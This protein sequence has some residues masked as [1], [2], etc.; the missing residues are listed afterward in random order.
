MKTYSF[1][2]SRS[3][4]AAVPYFP[5]SHGRSTQISRA[6]RPPHSVVRNLSLLGIKGRFG[7]FGTIRPNPGQTEISDVLLK[8]FDVSLSDDKLAATDVKNLR[9]EN[10]VVNGNTQS[11]K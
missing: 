7:S 11:E 8:D 9:F 3:I 1:A 2:A 6:K 5:F 4:R 10:V